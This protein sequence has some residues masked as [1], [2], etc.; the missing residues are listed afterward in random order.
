[1]MRDFAGYLLIGSF[2]ALAMGLAT[3][4]GL[5]LAVGARPVSEPGQVIQY[6][7]R[8][9]KGDRLNLHTTTGTGPLRPAQKQPAKMPVGC[10][11]AFSTLAASA[12]TNYS[13]R[14]VAQFPLH[15]TMAG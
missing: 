4:A 7:D 12:Q 8:T 3:V 1:M 14:C 6:V 15:R 2:A 9:H 13:G 5:G 11:P 10:E